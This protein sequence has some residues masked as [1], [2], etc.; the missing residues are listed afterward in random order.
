MR[1]GLELDWHDN[2]MNNKL[3]DNGI[4]HKADK[5]DHIPERSN[6]VDP[7]ALFFHNKYIVNLLHHSHNNYCISALARQ[8]V[9]APES[10]HYKHRLGRLYVRVYLQDSF[11]VRLEKKKA[12]LKIHTYLEQKLLLRQ[13]LQL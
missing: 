5:K 7:Q 1:K 3:Q 9:L 4:L 12:V 8:S 11:L 6:T 13:S 2:Y 10:S